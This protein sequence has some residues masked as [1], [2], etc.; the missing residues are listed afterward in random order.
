VEKTNVDVVSKRREYHPRRF[1][2]QLRYPLKSRLFEQQIG[3]RRYAS[4]D[5]LDEAGL[6][7]DAE[8]LDF[9]LSFRSSSSTAGHR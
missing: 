6:E 5:L 8:G 7:E 9:F 2:R 4:P 3:G 1:P